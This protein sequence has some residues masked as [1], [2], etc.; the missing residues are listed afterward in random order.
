MT[1]SRQSRVEFVGLQCVDHFI[2][3]EQKRN[4]KANRTPNVRVEMDYTDYTSRSHLRTGSHVS[5]EQ[6]T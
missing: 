4:R 1:N 3:L 2:S 5:H 6:E